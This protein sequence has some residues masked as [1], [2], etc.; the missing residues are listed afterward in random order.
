[1][2]NHFDVPKILAGQEA[3]AKNYGMDR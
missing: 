1:M 3:G 2:E